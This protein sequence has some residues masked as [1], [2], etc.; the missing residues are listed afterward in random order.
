[1]N[2]PSPLSRGDRVALIAPASPMQDARLVEASVSALQN[3]G[4]VPCPYPSCTVREGYLAGSDEMRARDLH[5]A[6]KDPDVSAIFCLRGGY[7]CMRL[8]PLLDFSLFEKYPKLLVGFSDVTALHLALLKRCRLSAL[9]AP[10]PFRY[11]QLSPASLARLGD[12]LFEPRGATYT[13]KDG[14]YCIHEGKAHGPLIGGNLGLVASLTHTEYC[15]A[16]NG[17]VLFLEEVGEEPYRID[18]L[19][20][21]LSLSGVFDQIA[22]L[23][24]GFFTDCGADGE[25]RAL[26]KERIPR[27]VPTLGGF[28]AGHELDNHAFFQGASVTLDAA[29]QTLWL[30]EI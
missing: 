18:R 12:C 13:K 19:L 2:Y 8:L 11:P 14:L 25:I 10:M 27:H 21:A 30:H 1:M 9:H 28:P 24:F 7:G 6:L 20:T 23:V 4:L 26:L 3:L 22:G 17:A 29:L 16:L 15:P 5:D